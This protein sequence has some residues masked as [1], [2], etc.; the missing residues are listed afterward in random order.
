M[1]LHEECPCASTLSIKVSPPGGS[2]RG[3]DENPSLSHFKPRGIS[4]S[5]SADQ[6]VTVLF[7]TRESRG[8]ITLNIV[9]YYPQSCSSPLNGGAES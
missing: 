3:S 2:V 7:K 5:G 1:Q 9:Y 4:A 6:S 8:K